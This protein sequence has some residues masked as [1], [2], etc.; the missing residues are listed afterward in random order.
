MNPDLKQPAPSSPSSFPPISELIKD[1]WHLFV[2]S[3]LNLFILNILSIVCSVLLAIVL[4][5]VVFFFG[6]ASAAILSGGKNLQSL[7]G[8]QIIIMAVICITIFV[9]VGT[10]IGSIVQTG[11]ILIL[12]AGD[13]HVS[14]GDV[15]KRSFRLIAP[16]FLVGFLIFCITFGSFFVFMIPAWF[17][18]IVFMFAP[19]EVVLENKRWTDAL[20]RSSA[21]VTS[22]FGEIFLRLL[23]IFGLGFLLGLVGFEIRLIPFVGG[24]LGFFFSLFTMLSGW[25][26]AA[27]YIT[28]YKQSRSLVDPAK[29]GSLMW[30]WIISG[31]GWVICL[32]VI[33][34]TIVFFSAF[35]FSGGFNKLLQKIQG[36]TQAGLYVPSACGLSLLHPTTTDT[37]NNKTRKWIL[38]EVR[39]K[40]FYILDSTVTPVQNTQTTFFRYRSPEDKLI[41]KNIYLPYPGLDISCIDNVKS[42]SL[43][44]YQALALAN[45]NIKVSDNKKFKSGEATILSLILE[46]AEDGKPFRDPAY[47]LVSEDGKKLIYMRIWGMSKSDP[48]YAEVSNDTDSILNNLKYRNSSD[49]PLEE[50]TP[51]QSKNNDSPVS[52]CISY[53]IREGE[54]ASNKCYVQK[55][56]DD[57]IYYLNRFNSAVFNN[58]AAVADMKITCSGSDFFKKT[59]EEDKAKQTKAQEDI[60]TYRGTIN[61]IIGR[62][63]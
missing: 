62:G 36:N 53:N 45:K 60:N 61:T 23:T 19:Y 35:A 54:F 22:H 7:L 25:F 3:L 27:Y 26:G 46:G 5:I 9:L 20:K 28:L 38:D 16:M 40:G 32:A 4:F 12:D 52:S 48:K 49:I 14:F 50:S 43:D 17:F 58:D 44:E 41:E 21:L 59:C 30:A 10:I 8:P 2:K 47:L 1:S 63:K 39:T 29:R 15:V 24:F 33:Y 18:T 11:T 37:Y 31:I 51:V 6:G 34:F 57:L 55:D 13:T 42:L 56:Y